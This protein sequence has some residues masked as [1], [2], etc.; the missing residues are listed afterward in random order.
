MSHTQNVQML[1]INL[2][3][4][5]YEIEEI[6]NKIIKQ[7]VGGR[8]LG[9]Y[10]LYKLVPAKADPLG[11]E[12]H[13][14]FT[15]GPTSGTN[16]PYGSKINLN[17][18]SP[19]TNIYLFS[20]SSGILCHQMRKAGFWAIVIKGV[21]ESPTY[22]AIHNHGVE[23]KDATG[24]WGMET[25]QAQQAMLGGVSAQKAA[26]VGIGPAGEQL[27]K[28]AAVF[29]DGPLY[30]CWG[31]G[32]AGCV[33]G[34]KK[35]KGM[36]VTGDGAVKIPDR[37]KVEAVKKEISH[38][39]QTEWKKWAEQWRRY[40]TGADLEL[41]NNLGILPTRNWQTGQFETWH[42]IDKTTT[43]MGWPE[44]GRACGPYC[45]TPGTRD[46]TVKEGPYKGAHSDVE[47]ETIYAFGS[48]CGVDKME[49][50]L[51]AGQI[52]DEFGIDTMT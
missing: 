5:S 33:M 31:R 32:G 47:W 14:I 10:L 52:C 29:S 19:L 23:F 49:A 8:G 4:R 37:D 51:A 35:L 18:K 6:P 43:P 2:S 44:K 28:Y 26:T 27:I 30:R 15:A 24:L 46:V 9:S 36:V 42:G 11:E 7:Y 17:T 21:A 3:T 13:L 48:S 12:N 50:V 34:S 22:L 38:K 1:Q 20:I 39:V 25:A 16:F 41:M 45:L 40:E